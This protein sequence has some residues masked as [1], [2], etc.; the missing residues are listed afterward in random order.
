MAP[1]DRCQSLP[2][3]ALSVTSADLAWPRRLSDLMPAERQG[4]A[5]APVSR[6]A[7]QCI[8]PP[9]P[10]ARGMLPA[11]LLFVGTPLEMLT[12][13]Y[14]PQEFAGAGGRRPRTL[15]LEQRVQFRKAGDGLQ[16]QGPRWW[17]GQECPRSGQAIR[18]L[19]APT[20]WPALWA[21]DLC[22][23]T[24]PTLRRI[25]AHFQTS[26]DTAFL[27]PELAQELVAYTTPLQGLT[28]LH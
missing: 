24:D 18:G 13:R 22:G 5:R 21:Q 7:V 20:G 16:G 15:A 28:V 2:C 1:G 25:P 23:H 26:V 3:W 27:H 14:G 6:V 8:S 17:L 9:A 10:E 11:P 4:W 19:R 12:S